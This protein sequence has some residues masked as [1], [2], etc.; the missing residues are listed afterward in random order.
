MGD[1]P[2]LPNRRSQSASDRP[3]V[4]ARGTRLRHPA[5]NTRNAVV[6]EGAVVPGRRRVRAA[7]RLLIGYGVVGILAAAIGIVFLVVGLG[8]VNALAGRVDEL[9]G[10]GRIMDRTATVLEDA[11]SSARGFAS[12]IDG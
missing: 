6:V 5:M 1:R 2:R 12:T 8:R 10:I 11:A 4:A 7:S 3:L 9:G